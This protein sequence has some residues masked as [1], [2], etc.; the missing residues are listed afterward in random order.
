MTAQREE[1]MAE[2]ERQRLLSSVNHTNNDDDDAADVKH[3]HSHSLSVPIDVASS[4]KDVHINEAHR[5]KAASLFRRSVSLAGK[6]HRRVINRYSDSDDEDI[7]GPPVPSTDADPQQ[8]QHTDSDSEIGPPAPPAVSSQDSKQGSAEQNESSDEE[9]GP[10]VPDSAAAASGGK[11]DEINSQED[12]LAG[13]DDDDD[14][15]DDDDNDDSNDEVT[16]CTC[17]LCIYNV[18]LSKSVVTVI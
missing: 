4:I 6:T 2:E 14:D 5:S 11:Q 16:V 13:S 17:F 9:I 18:Y 10:A 1:R 3:A 8:L 7:I 12:R 15:D